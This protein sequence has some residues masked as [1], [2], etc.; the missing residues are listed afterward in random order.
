MKKI[1]L[2]F[3]LMWQIV[4]A[5]QIDV[6]SVRVIEKTSNGG[7]Y[8]PVFSPSNQFLLAT[9]AGYKGLKMISFSDNEIKTITEEPGAGYGVRISNDGNTIVYKKNE[10]IKN[11]KYSSLIVHTLKTG[12]EKQLVSRTRDQLTPAISDSKPFYVKGSKLNRKSISTDELIPVIQTEDRK[13]AL[14]NGENRKVLTPNGANESYFWSSI[15][16]DFEKIVYTVAG[17]GTFVCDING[18][19]VKSLGKLSAPK[20][21]NNN[22]LIGMDDKDNGQELISSVIVAVTADGKNRQALTVQ[23][24]VKAMYPSASPDAKQIAFCTDNGQLFLINID[25]K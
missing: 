11:L 5:Q 21:L 14:Y 23:E 22:W 8:H 7:Y 13:L 2:L 4:Y 17:K 16:P 6:L 9:D 15:S 20:W 3:A 18:T 25:I 1:L 19:N 12:S 10:L 24:E